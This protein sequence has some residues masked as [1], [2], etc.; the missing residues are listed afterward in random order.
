MYSHEAIPLTECLT[1][2]DETCQALFC[3]FDSIKVCIAVI[4]RTPDAPDSSFAGV[5]KFL[6]KCIKDVDDDSY[7]FNLLGDYNFPDI[8]W[9]SL[10]ALPGNSRESRLSA[11]SL[12]NFMSDNLLNQYVH[13]PTRGINTLDLFITNNPYLV[14]NVSDQD[15]DLSD[16]DLVDIVISSNPTLGYKEVSSNFEVNDFRSLD[17]TQAKFDEIKDSLKNK[18]WSSLRASC[19]S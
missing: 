1:Y 2:D 5:I 19:S 17:F 3:R 8:D 18:D 16:Y 9:Q 6:D 13:I 4:Y 14:T 11:E 7:Q 10:V 15:T 12:L